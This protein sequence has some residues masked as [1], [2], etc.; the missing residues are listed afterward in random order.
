M[1]SDAR[2]FH[3][4]HANNDGLN[5]SENRYPRF[6]L[7]FDPG[8]KE[9]T[10]VRIVLMYMKSYGPAWNGSIVRMSGEQED[11]NGSKHKLFEENLLGHFQEHEPQIS[12]SLTSRFS[13]VSPS[14]GLTRI[15]FELIGGKQFKFTG[16]VFC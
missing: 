8:Y 3:E 16:M 14:N 9:G 1:T 2:P 12:V 7:V 6:D 5:A 13:H 4:G 15:K 11:K 10:T